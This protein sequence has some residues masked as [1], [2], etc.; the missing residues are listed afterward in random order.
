V[1]GHPNDK[2]YLAGLRS[3]AY[4][5]NRVT[6]GLGAYYGYERLRPGLFADL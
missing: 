3:A 2:A 1:V 5:A 6:T 4:I